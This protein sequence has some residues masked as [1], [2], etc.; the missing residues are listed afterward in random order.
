MTVQIKL[1][2]CAMIVMARSNGKYHRP[3]I[4]SNA[5]LYLKRANWFVKWNYF[6]CWLLP[7]RKHQ[8]TSRTIKKNSS[9]ILVNGSILF[10]CPIAWCYWPGGY[11]SNTKCGCIIQFGHPFTKQYAYAPHANANQGVFVN[12]TTKKGKIKLNQQG[13]HRNKTNQPGPIDQ[14]HQRGES[15]SGSTIHNL[16]FPRV[17]PPPPPPS[18]LSSSTNVLF[19]FNANIRT[20][21]RNKPTKVKVKKLHNNLND[22]QTRMVTGIIIF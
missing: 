6:F 12:E 2:I 3:S 9:I 10:C 21:T 4:E 20:Y 11:V 8:E 14:I 7:A 19:T 17:Y 16:L 18:P 15:C 13:E 5:F 22:G 1:P